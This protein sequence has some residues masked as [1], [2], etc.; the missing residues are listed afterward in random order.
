VFRILDPV[1]PID[2]MQLQWYSDLFTFVPFRL[3]SACMLSP[4]NMLFLTSGNAQE[5]ERITRLTS[6]TTCISEAMNRVEKR[7]FNME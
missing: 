1:F 6:G 5:V 3:Y 2:F 4:C 7:I